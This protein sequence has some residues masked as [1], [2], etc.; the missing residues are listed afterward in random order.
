MQFNFNT[1]NELTREATAVCQQAVSGHRH[2][3]LRPRP[4][5]DTFTPTH[6]IPLK[7][8]GSVRKE[9]LGES[10]SLCL[11]TLVRSRKELC[12]V[13]LYERSA[14]PSH[15]VEIDF[16][17]MP[18][19]AEADNFT[20]QAVPSVPMDLLE[21]LKPL[22]VHSL[23]D[24]EVLL[25]EEKLLETHSS[26]IQKTCW[27]RA[28]CVLRR[29]HSHSCGPAAILALLSRYMACFQYALELRCVQRSIPLTSPAEDDDTNQS[30]SSIEDDFVTALDHLD[31]GEAAVAGHL[32][33]HSQQD[34]IS[35]TVPSHHQ[36]KLGSSIMLVSRG[37]VSSV[38]QTACSGE[39]LLAQSSILAHSSGPERQW[40]LVS[41]SCPG[42]GCVFSAPP[43]ES[44]D[45]DRSSPSPIIFLDEAGYQKSLRAKLN[46]PKI[47]VL[48]DGV[49]S[50]DSEV[51]KFFDSFE[52]FDDLD[53]AFEST[54]EPLKELN[55]AGQMQK[56]AFPGDFASIAVTTAVNLQR[57]DQP[58]FPVNVKRPTPF[59]PLSPFGICPD[60]P[61]S[62]HWVKPSYEENGTLLSL[63]KSSAFS[64]MRD[65]TSMPYFWKRYEDCSELAKPHDHCTLYQKYLDFASNI[66]REI[67]RSVR[68]H[69]SLIDMTAN[70]NLSCVCHKEFKNSSGHMMKLS[71]IQEAVTI[72]QSQKCQSLKEGIQKF[73]TDLVDMSLGSAL[74][75]LQ[76]GLAS[77]TTTLCH[78]AARLTSSVFQM[79]FQ[80]IGMKRALILKEHAVNGLA[81][82][83]VGE[84]VSGALKEFH[85]VKKQIF[86]NTVARFAAD[87][88]EELVFEGIM[89]VCQF[90]HPS[91]PLTLSERSVQEEEKVVSVYASD[92][93]ESVLQ[94]AFIE[95]SQ[96]DVTSTAKP[97]IS[98]SLDNICYVSAEDTTKTTRTCNA[99]TSYFGLSCTAKSVNSEA[100]NGCSVGKALF[101]MSGIASCIPVPAAGK[102]VSQLHNPA[103]TC[104]YKSSVFQTSQAGPRK[105]YFSDQ[106][107]VMA[108]ASDSSAGVQKNLLLSVGQR[109]EDYYEEGVLEGA[110]SFTTYEKVSGAT[111][112]REDKVSS[113]TGNIVDTICGEDYKLSS[114]TEVTKGAGG[115]ADCL[116]RKIGVG[117][118]SSQQISPSRH[119]SGKVISNIS[120]LSESKCQNTARHQLEMYS[121][122]SEDTV[123]HPL[124]SQVK[125]I[126]PQDAAYLNKQ[127]ITVQTS[128]SSAKPLINTHLKGQIGEIFLER[129]PLSTKDSLGV[130]GFE[131]AGRGCKTTLPD[132]LLSSSGR[133][134]S[135]TPSI[136]Q[137]D[138]SVPQDKRVE[139]FS[140]TLKGKHVNEFFPTPPPSTPRDQPIGEEVGKGD[141]IAK[142]TRSLSDEAGGAEDNQDSQEYSSGPGTAFKCGQGELSLLGETDYRVGQAALC[143]AGRLV[144][145]II[146]MATEM[147]SLGLEDKV[148]LNGSD[149]KDGLPGHFA[150]FSEDTLKSL[151]AYAGEVVGEVIADVIISIQNSEFGGSSKDSNSETHKDN[152]GVSSITVLKKEGGQRELVLE[153]YA[154]RLAYQSIKKGLAQAAVKPRQQTKLG[155]D[156]LRRWDG[157]AA[158]KSCRCIDLEMPS[159]NASS[160][161][162]QH[163]CQGVTN[164]DRREHMELVVFAESLACNIICD[165][166]RKLRPSS[167]Q[168]PKSLT[169]S[170][171]Y[172]KSTVEDDPTYLRFSEPCKEKPKQY[173]SMGCLNE[174][175]YSGF[176]MK[177]IEHYAKKIVDDTLELVITSSCCQPTKDSVEANK[178]S[179]THQLSTGALS[180]SLA[181]KTCCYCKSIFRSKHR[182]ISRKRSQ[183]Y[184]VV[185][186][187]CSSHTRMCGCD[188]PQIYINSVKRAEFAEAMVSSA[189]E[190]A[191][192]ELSNT[193]LNVDSG[194]GHDGA[195]FAE[196]V[197]N[198]I[199]TSVM[200]NVP[201]T[202]NISPEAGDGTCSSESHRSRRLSR[203]TREDSL[204]SWSNLSF[205]D[206][207]LD[208]SSSFL[209]LSDSQGTGSS[210]GS[211]GL[212][213]QEP[214][215]YSPA[216]SSVI[217]EKEVELQ[218]G[219]NGQ[220]RCAVSGLTVRNVDHSGCGLDPQARAVLQWIAASLSDL[221][222]IRLVQSGAELQQLPAVLCRVRERG[223]TAGDLLQVLLKYCESQP[224]TEEPRCIPFFH[225][226]LEHT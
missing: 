15:P 166:T 132:E 113:L 125:S 153:Q 98:M 184:E 204:G 112:F 58:A 213:G 148:K 41:P 221:P 142:L 190:K 52:H 110:R 106:C 216:N 225:W 71:E 90:S 47:P 182:E 44:E 11:E 3:H 88:A 120:P 81:G 108:L 99:A 45:S 6:G 215:S 84:A 57:F 13:V 111:L 87:L 95:L 55:N 18:S 14:G 34:S 24:E 207:H 170:C 121:A 35:Q 21:S 50:S 194:I 169:D 172:K 129:G 66:S 210:W 164:T 222:I 54:S 136:P 38:N 135:R 157:H 33:P 134:H 124:P 12:R 212:D 183:D 4:A 105:G 195:S 114:A 62:P 85:F 152:C 199:M 104:Q 9:Y 26:V 2:P 138:P 200:S 162:V 193:S 174:E 30:I 208:E 179:Q 123:L 181:D 126:G 146:S 158:C 92:L 79:A 201:Q 202:T 82:F 59:K 188:I 177:V 185:S 73:A 217:E 161:A 173:H 23:K 86:N 165:V 74:R 145:H 118:P 1:K 27:S 137:Q 140:E 151:W 226:L 22:H 186:D 176:V 197:A 163:I 97:T 133:M 75:D 219:I 130:L 198:D 68:G 141:F 205:E 103:K 60:V 101:C 149:R 94:E 209:H 51:S 206:E 76:K 189:M 180:A 67:L 192:K 102:G 43:T 154:S 214:R 159:E 93:S 223:W 109:S 116:S 224:I 96:A 178:H 36:E 131:L 211:L 80:E 61:D 143:Y 28:V 171:L 25:L 19:V 127:S 39:L 77:C 5:M 160:K 167:I 220:S 53:Q 191:K 7:T 8:W 203:S 196:S 119:T 168:L 139:Q 70:K 89:E 63:E 42:K 144:S 40:S 31:K 128:L 10:S 16:V 46:I 91:T 49:E 65:G 56:R 78:L 122:T 20:L 155:V 83:L 48:K 117:I 17:C 150:R 29:P 156:P 100:E 37:S 187:H 72:S 32:S 175:T 218:D 107:Q 147:E 115:F 69:S 64:P